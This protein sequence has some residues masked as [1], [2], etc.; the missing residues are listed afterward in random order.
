MVQLSRPSRLN[1][2]WISI[3]WS[4]R[5]DHNA[6]LSPLG[7]P[8]VQE[9]QAKR[10]CSR[11]RTGTE[12]A[13]GSTTN[14]QPSPSYEF[15]SVSASSG[16]SDEPVVSASITDVRASNKETDLLFSRTLTYCLI[17]NALPAEEQKEL[18]G[19]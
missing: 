12:F 4:D 10:I 9:Q 6:L 3:P 15:H 5:K 11:A 16:S 18:L 8:H 13:S 14:I 1:H 2:L 17:K 7:S 19:F